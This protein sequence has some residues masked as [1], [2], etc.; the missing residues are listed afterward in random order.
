MKTKIGIVLH[1]VGDFLFYSR[2]SL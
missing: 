1:M 2:V